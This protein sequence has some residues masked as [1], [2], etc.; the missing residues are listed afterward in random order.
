MF[1]EMGK[2]MQLFL[3]IERMKNQKTP[4]GKNQIPIKKE[5]LEEIKN[6]AE[7]VRKDVIP[8]LKNI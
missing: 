1:S 5:I 6:T 7:G 8:A 3:R 2:D 4:A